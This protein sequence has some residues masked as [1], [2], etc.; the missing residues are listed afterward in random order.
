MPAVTPTLPPQVSPPAFALSGLQPHA[1]SGVEVLALPYTRHD[2]A[3]ILGDE[4]RAAGEALGIDLLEVLVSARARG[5]AGEV[6]SV[7]LSGHGPSLVLFI[8]ATARCAHAARYR[9]RSTGR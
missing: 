3:P 5:G 8:A 6:V 9:R 2:D 7:P 1:L 4:G